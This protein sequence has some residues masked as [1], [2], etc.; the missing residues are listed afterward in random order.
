MAGASRNPNRLLIP[1]S[2]QPLPPTPAQQPQAGAAQLA[3]NPQNAQ[4]NG[5]YG[6]MYGLAGTQ[7]AGQQVQ[8]QIQTNQQAGAAQQ[9]ALSGGYA[10]TG[11]LPGQLMLAQ[12]QG[13][14]RGANIAANATNQQLGVLQG[15]AQYNASAPAPVAPG[16]FTYPLVNQQANTLFGTGNTL[17]PALPQGPTP[18]PSSIS[19]SSSFG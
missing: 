13:A 15:Q 3:A 18:G 12:S 7:Q 5:I 14:Q 11:I 10:N 8:N 19:T 4:V 1:F 17:P 9:A 2:F 16:Q 6:Q